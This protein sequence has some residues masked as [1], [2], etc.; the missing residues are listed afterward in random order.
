MSE[1]KFTSGQKVLYLPEN[2]IYDFGYYGATGK[3]I[4]YNEGER[5]MQ[6]SYAVN[7]NDLQA[8]APKYNEKWLRV[9]PDYCSCGL[10][11]KEGCE[12]NIDE[13]PLSANLK[14]W[15]SHWCA[16]YEMQDDYLP[17]DERRSPEFPLA[18]FSM[19]GERI[20]QQIKKELPDWTV[21]Y[22][23]CWVSS[24]IPFPDGDRSLYEYEITL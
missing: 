4:I 5:N 10:W 8:G 9:M 3:A 22:F 19:W 12:V 2:K 17:E 21:I 16:M 6:D 7:E 23:N 11:E 20:A 13:I 14:R 24:M 1:T 18:W 15:L